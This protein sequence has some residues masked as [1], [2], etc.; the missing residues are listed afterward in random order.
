[1]K[2]LRLVAVACTIGLTG[3]SMPSPAPLAAIRRGERSI[4]RQYL[5]NGTNDWEPSIGLGPNNAVYV[6]ATRARERGADSGRATN[7][8]V[9]SS[10]GGGDTFAPAVTLLPNDDTQ[11]DARVVV[12]TN[13]VVYASWISLT[14]VAIATSRDAGRSYSVH[15]IPRQDITDKPELA[16]SADGRDLYVAAEARGGLMALVS[17]D[18][19]ATWARHRILPSDSVHHWPTALRLGPDGTIWLSTPAVTY[20]GLHDTIADVDLYIYSSRDQGVT[21][22]GTRLARATRADTR[23]LHTKECPAVFPYPVI[24]LRSAREMIAVYVAAAPGH[25]R[26]LWLVRS[27][28]GG[29]SWSAPAVIA[30][31]TRAASHD[32]ADTAVPDVVAADTL[33][34]V[35]WADDRAGPYSVWAKRSTDGG[36]SWSPDVRLSQPG[37]SRESGYFGHYGGSAID[38]QGRLVTVWSEGTG[39]IW[40]TGQGGTWYA[41]WNGH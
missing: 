1:M 7:I 14:D 11:G 34:Y 29:S 24:A 30:N 36:R 23:C 16:V 25:A 10:P 13:G 26:A 21:W 18:A 27:S 17:H 39:K 19:G 40:L 38:D 15:L 32:H 22:Q 12:D 8:V 9:W 41:R 4:V 20:R 33:V 3:G 35:V 31:P 6:S 5:S 28:D 37:Q 2:W